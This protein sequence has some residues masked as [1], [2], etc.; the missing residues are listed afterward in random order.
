MGA[1]AQEAASIAEALGPAARSGDND[2][3]SA[4]SRVEFVRSYLERV[5]KLLDHRPEPTDPV[6]PELD[7]GGGMLDRISGLFRRD[8]P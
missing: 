2:F 1:L 7:P 3:K 4:L 5:G 8:D 6:E